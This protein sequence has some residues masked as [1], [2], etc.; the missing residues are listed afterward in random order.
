MS[1]YRPNRA[2]N[3][4]CVFTLRSHPPFRGMSCTA[5]TELV[6]F[7]STGL[8]WR[9][10]RRG[11]LLSERRK[12]LT[13]QGGVLVFCCLLLRGDVYNQEDYSTWGAACETLVKS[14]SCAG[15]RWLISACIHSWS[16]AVWLRVCPTHGHSRRPPFLNLTAVAP[17][18]YPTARQERY[19]VSRGLGRGAKTVK[20]KA[21]ST[22]G[23][24]KV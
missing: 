9:R 19:C 5:R 4:L 10:L 2:R 14:R 21:T 18:G 12:R 16:L 22:S 17:A 13:V 8:A 20:S 6:G 15:A 3:W 24:A 23:R 7:V 1:C 11:T